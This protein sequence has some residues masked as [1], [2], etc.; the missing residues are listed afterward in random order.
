MQRLNSV[1]SGISG[2][3]LSA[4][5][6]SRRGYIAS[7]TLRN[8]KGVD[9]LVANADASKSLAIQVKTNQGSQKWWLLNKKA[10]GFY[11]RNLFYIFVN[12]NDGNSAEFFIV[13]SKAVSD[14]VKKSHARWL[15][16]P[17][18]RGQ[19]HK[20]NPMRVFID[21]EMKYLNRWDLLSL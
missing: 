14:F 10:E 3:Y 18:K 5:E 2:E 16:T 21:R 11:A 7:L 20:D 1:S 17:G 15:K 19:P 13:P 4:G 12:L 6:L 8:S 9:I